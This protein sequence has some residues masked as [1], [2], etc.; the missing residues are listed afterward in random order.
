MKLYLVCVYSSFLEHVSKYAMTLLGFM[1]PPRAQY[2]VIMLILTT[3]V[4][5]TA[6]TS[7]IAAAG[8]ELMSN[9]IDLA[10][11]RM[12]RRFAIVSLVL[13]IV[14]QGCMCYNINSSKDARITKMTT[15]DM[16]DV[17][18]EYDL[19][20]AVFLTMM[21]LETLNAHCASMLLSLGLYKRELI[22]RTVI[23]VVIQL[24]L[25]FFL[26]SV[27]DF[28]VR[29]LFYAQMTGVT[30]NLLMHVI[31]IFIIRWQEV[32]F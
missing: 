32:S 1:L 6:M 25:A 11:P 27:T 28:G 18:E 19:L 4:M 5:Q 13:T 2:V 26:M 14:V 30:I 29:G 22:T 9:E 17:R 7:T 16:Q 8:K 10:N 21:F 23:L 12:A 15:D 24:P 31:K 3:G 20:I